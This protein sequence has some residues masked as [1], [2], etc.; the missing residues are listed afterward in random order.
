MT[1]QTHTVILL[2]LNRSNDVIMI[3]NTSPWPGF[4][5]DIP[6]IDGSNAEEFVMKGVSSQ[7]LFVGVERTDFSDVRTEI[8]EADPEGEKPWMGYPFV[9]THIEHLRIGPLALSI[10]IRN[11]SMYVRVDMGSRGCTLK[12]AGDGGSPYKTCHSQF[13]YV[14]EWEA[15]QFT[16]TPDEKYLSINHKSLFNF[17]VYA[18]Q[19]HDRIPEF[20]PQPQYMYKYISD[21]VSVDKLDAAQVTIHTELKLGKKRGSQADSWTRKY[22]NVVEKMST[23][24][25]YVMKHKRET[26][27]NAQMALAYGLSGES[28]Q[29]KMLLSDDNDITEELLVRCD[30][31]CAFPKSQ[32]WWYLPTEDTTIIHG[33][34]KDVKV[35]DD[36]RS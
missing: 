16:D 20:N 28:P 11:K 9:G 26:C 7:G 30:T 36:Y 18:R 27:R 6:T 1:G 5:P 19:C 14:A 23:A 3:Q 15:F 10:S 33:R 8:Y 24:H 29:V 21:K 25:E 13:E 4:N 12:C 22:Q 32:L 2:R 17:L 35:I 34:K 31:L